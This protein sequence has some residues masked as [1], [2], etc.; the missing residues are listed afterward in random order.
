MPITKR[1]NSMYESI[2]EKEKCNTF[3]QRVFT[4]F[5]FFSD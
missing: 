1:K 3:K 5:Q 2:I 4:L